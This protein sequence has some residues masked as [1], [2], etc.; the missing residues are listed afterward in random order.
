MCHVFF[1]DCNCNRCSTGVKNT[2]EFHRISFQLLAFVCD[3]VNISWFCLKYCMTR[4]IFYD[5]SQKKIHGAQVN[6]V[7]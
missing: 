1:S 2:T 4:A 7:L 6:N 3:C 5:Y